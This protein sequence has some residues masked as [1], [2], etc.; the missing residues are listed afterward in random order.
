MLQDPGP[1]KLK[2]WPFYLA[3]L[4]LSAVVVFVLY[5]L[6]TFEGSSEM[7]LVGLC[8]AAAAVGAWISI[9]P[10][11]REHAAG[12]HL[13]DSTNLKTSLEQIKQVEK[14]ADLIRQANSQWQGV[15]DAS[16]RTVASAREIS[17]K[18]K[19]ETDE[20][21]KFMDQAR[22]QERAGLRLE[23]EKLRRMEADWIKVAVQM[24]DHTYAIYRAAERSGQQK[25]IAQLGQFQ[26][27]CRD[28]TRRLGL[29]PFT[30]A[31]GEK[32]DARAHQ[33]TDPK[34]TPPD[35]AQV[36]EVLATGFTYQ[37]QLLRRSLVLLANPEPQ[38]RAAAEESAPELAAEEPIE[39]HPRPEPP[40]QSQSSSEPGTL[41]ASASYASEAEIH[42]VSAA[43]EPASPQPDFSESI[44][45][46][47]IHLEEAEEKAGRKPSSQ[48]E[49][50]F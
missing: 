9:I 46:G 25:L 11:L 10:W 40:A 1:A 36:G 12:L 16:I 7:I 38:P 43:I 45:L 34:F 24:L 21:M 39:N 41:C 8:L 20:F 32:F 14:V 33:L 3:D 5:R 18:M 17:D 23:V 27:A 49:L 15:Q 13:A 44:P 4:L 31:L 37:G 35:D 29:A 26:N 47:S 6:G 50:P 42:Q 2:K 30:P 22:D 19:I 28:V 48:E